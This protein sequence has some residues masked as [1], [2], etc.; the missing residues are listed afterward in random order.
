MNKEEEKKGEKEKKAKP[1]KAVK[2]E[3]AGVSAK[4][5]KAASSKEKK[6][7][8]KAAPKPDEDAAAAE[9]EKPVRVKT[10]KKKSVRKKTGSAGSGTTKK[11]TAQAP[12]G[13]VSQLA[14]EMP[15]IIKLKYGSGTSMYS[16]IG[17]YR[18]NSFKNVLGRTE[19]ERLIKWRKEE[20]Y[21]TIE[22]ST[23]LDRARSLGYK[24]KQGVTLVRVRVRR[25]GLRK[26]HIAK[27][28]RAKR[29]GILRITMKKNTQ[30]IA[31]ERV[32]KRY[33]NM[34]VLNSY[35]VGQD[36][37]HKW[38]EV[39]LVDPYNPSVLSDRKLNW[40]SN[41]THSSRAFRGLTSAGK[42]GRG[43][44]WKGKGVEKVRP[45]IR[46]NDRQGK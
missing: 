31:E 24:S 19:W 13:P 45:S 38:Y 22:H 37:M 40:L 46:A 27:G 30:R 11:T 41:Q 5:E 15:P 1:A 12:A 4:T 16:H 2:H 14:R 7:W 28:R 23:R 44:R 26:R 10:P 21:K 20:N 29:K 6:S 17:S 34:E 33:P 25:G 36:G 8:K 43:L 18:K 35:H 32:G 39:I 3:R 9:A 42:R